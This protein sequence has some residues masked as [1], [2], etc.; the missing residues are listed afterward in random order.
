MGRSKQAE[1]DRAAKRAKLDDDDDS[2]THSASSDGSVSLLDS[3]ASDAGNESSSVAK[4]VSKDDL[5]SKSASASKSTRHETSPS[6]GKAKD[7]KKIISVNADPQTFIQLSG[8]DAY[9]ETIKQT[10]LQLTLDLDDTSLKKLQDKY[11]KR[12][13]DAS[14]GTHEASGNAS[15]RFSKSGNAQKKYSD[16]MLC[17]QAKYKLIQKGLKTVNDMV[18]AHSAYADKVKSNVIR[19]MNSHQNLC[20]QVTAFRND[21]AANAKHAAAAATRKGFL[22]SVSNKLEKLVTAQFHL[23]TSLNV[24]LDNKPYEDDLIDNVK[25]TKTFMT[26]A[27]A[28]TGKEAPLQIQIDALNTEVANKNASIL[29]QANSISTLTATLAAVQGS[30][31]KLIATEAAT[32]PRQILSTGQLKQNRADRLAIIAKHQDEQYAMFEDKDGHTSN[33]FRNFKVLLKNTMEASMRGLWNRHALLAVWSIIMP[34]YPFTDTSFKHFHIRPD[35]AAS[36]PYHALTDVSIEHG[37]GTVTGDLPDKD[38]SMGQAMAAVVQQYRFLLENMKHTRDEC[39][40]LCAKR[41]KNDVPTLEQLRGVRWL[42]SST[43]LV[44]IPYEKYHEFLPIKGSGPTDFKNSRHTQIRTQIR[45][46]TGWDF[47]NKKPTYMQTDAIWYLH[48]VEKHTKRIYNNYYASI[49][50]KEKKTITSMLTTFLPAEYYL[51]DEAQTAPTD[52]SDPRLLSI[53]RLGYTGLLKIM[54]DEE[55][56]TYG[57]IMNIGASFFEAKFNDANAKYCYLQALLKPQ[58]LRC[59]IDNNHPPAYL[60]KDM[61]EKWSK[62]DIKPLKRSQTACAE[63]KWVEYFILN[64]TLLQAHSEMAYTHYLQQE[65]RPKQF[66]AKYTPLQNTPLVQ[67]AF[68]NW[69]STTFEALVAEASALN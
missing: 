54:R 16:L 44:P 58:D 23:Q 37:Y 63:Q 21:T 61:R 49:R 33:T 25:L 27:I 38:S 42:S 48:F 9:N 60:H 22:T 29:S 28:L 14:S 1:S 59:R 57:T 13:S 55:G 35:G 10:N 18:E 31:A 62:I 3:D 68:N 32:P 24:L 69:P 17:D 12:L 52:T 26:D 45:L 20:D 47:D 6:G 11:L 46:F 43:G 34:D 30:A 64:L 67:A 40:S 15:Q 5:V 19:L 2:D 7:A 36:K 56:S 51:Y 41:G 50:A 53:A 65:S 66:D 4:G 8:L 39:T